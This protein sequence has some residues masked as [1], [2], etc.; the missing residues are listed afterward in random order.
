MSW[1]CTVGEF[2]QLVDVRMLE[3]SCSRDDVH[4]TAFT[5]QIAV[6]DVNLELQSIALS[7]LPYGHVVVY[8]QFTGPDDRVELV[9][10]SIF[11]EKPASTGS[12][13]ISNSNFTTLDEETYGLEIVQDSSLTVEFDVAHQGNEFVFCHLSPRTM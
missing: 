7:D 9:E 11:V 12:L 13:T 4:V 5:Q 6:P 10:R 2:E 1:E 8:I 3:Y